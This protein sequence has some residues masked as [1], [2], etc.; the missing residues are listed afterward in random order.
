MWWG[1]TGE[2]LES[3]RWIKK[4]GGHSGCRDATEQV[5]ILRL[6]EW[7]DWIKKQ[8][9]VIGTRLHGS[10]ATLSQEV[11]ALIICHDM[12][13]KEM[14]EL[15]RFLHISLSAAKHLSLEDMYEQ[16]AFREMHDC[17]VQMS[18]NMSHSWKKR[19]PA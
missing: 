5:S 4:K 2:S 10:V 9:F 13:T 8:E 12:R 6:K 17:Y 3:E 15:M 19:H 1:S 11:P 7:F 14:C 16:T 18:P